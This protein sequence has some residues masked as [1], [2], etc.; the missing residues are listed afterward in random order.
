MRF[1]PTISRLALLLPVLS[2]SA[3]AIER[4]VASYNIDTEISL[5]TDQRTRGISDSL[6]HPALQLHTEIAHESGIIALAEIVSVSKKQFVGGSG[7]GVTLGLGYRWGDPEAWHFGVGVATELFPGAKFQAPHS[8]DLNTFTPGD[9]K[10]TDFNSNFLLFEANYGA[11]EGRMLYVVS[12]TYR[13]ADTGGV[14]G[15][16]L[17]LATDPTDALACYGR[18]DHNSRGSMLFDLNYSVDLLPATT[19]TLH[20][21]QQKVE[22]FKEADFSDYQIGIS[23]AQW[24]FDWSLDWYSTDSNARELYQVQDGNRLRATDNDAFVFSVTRS[25]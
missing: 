7:T 22:N 25:F 9:F 15:Q 1:M 23:R 21:G 10:S 20:V 19:L 4:E 13:G 11:I 8:F 12:D 2:G 6:L 24:G 18:G 16:M 17:Q 5:K 14:C 3:C